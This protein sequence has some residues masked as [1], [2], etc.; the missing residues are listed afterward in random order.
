MADLSLIPDA[1]WREA[2]RR[3]A[4]QDDRSEAATR[5]GSHGRARHECGRALRRA[6]RHSPDALSP[7]VD[8]RGAL[9]TDG[10]KL[11]GRAGER[12][13]R[14]PDGHP[15]QHD[16]SKIGAWGHADHV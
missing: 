6:R 14:K 10:E 3:T 8:P 11:L 7:H 12:K 9:R 16:T 15:F 2:Q 1:A 13:G 4:I 5:S